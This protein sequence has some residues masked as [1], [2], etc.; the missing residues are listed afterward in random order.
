M[1]SVPVKA[2]LWMAANP[3]STNLSGKIEIFSQWHVPTDT[4]K[5]FLHRDFI[6][7]D[8][9]WGFISN[10]ETFQHLLNKG[11]RYAADLPFSF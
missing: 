8:A 7:Q 5:L 4:I 10:P 6:F 11:F 1:G 3:S 2:S 9:F